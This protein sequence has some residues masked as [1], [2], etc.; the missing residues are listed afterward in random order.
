MTEDRARRA[1]APPRAGW[2]WIPLLGILS[3]QLHELG[4]YLWSVLVDRVE[5]RM[6]FARVVDLSGRS[7]T[8]ESMA[9]GPIDSALLTLIGVAMLWHRS[10][11][12][13][14]VGAGLALAMS[15]SRLTIY[16]ISL[17][18]GMAGNDEG[19]VSRAVGGGDWTLALLLLPFFV[20]GV[21]LPVW[22]S[23]LRPR[24]LV[25]LVSYVA[26]FFST[27]AAFA[28]DRAVFGG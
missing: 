15:L 28:L 13:R 9:A 18:L 2:I 19:L 23:P 26:V 27:L 7:G 1:E 3:T 24:W 12:V 6:Q 14:I 4:H 25:V 16:A 20:G 10:V 22:R 11:H 5:V 21:V 8:I 17:D